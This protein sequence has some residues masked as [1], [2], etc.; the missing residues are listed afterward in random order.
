MHSELKGGDGLRV[1]VLSDITQKFREIV[2]CPEEFMKLEKC[3]DPSTAERLPY[4]IVS[5]S[6]LLLAGTYHGG[7]LQLRRPFCNA[8]STSPKVKA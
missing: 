5:F 7:C 8:G 1:M 2:S 4:T 3:H 6:P